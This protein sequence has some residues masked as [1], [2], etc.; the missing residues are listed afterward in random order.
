M[1]SRRLRNVRSTSVA[2]LVALEALAHAQVDTGNGQ[3]PRTNLDLPRDAFDLKPRREDL[4]VPATWRDVERGSAVEFHPGADAVSPHAPA[5]LMAKQLVAYLAAV[6]AI[7]E[8]RGD[9]AITTSRDPAAELRRRLEEEPAEWVRTEIQVDIAANGDVESIAVAASSG[10]RELDREALRA[11]KRAL[12]RR[13][14]VGKTAATARFACD[15]G[16]VATPPILGKAQGDLRNQG[17]AA[18]MRIRFDETTRTVDPL[19]PFVRR[20][21]TRIRIIDYSERK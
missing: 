9:P 10:R 3:P 16:V 1:S 8:G 11:V 5:A 18:G 2:L 6:R 14:P 13:H 15:A 4:H 19:I 7:E 12:T 20:V 21:L 17:I